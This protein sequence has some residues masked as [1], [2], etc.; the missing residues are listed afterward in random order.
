MI[1]TSNQIPA[2]YPNLVEKRGWLVQN[3]GYSAV[4]FELKKWGLFVPFI[5]Y[6]TSK[7][8]LFQWQIESTISTTQHLILTG[9][10]F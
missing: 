1:I 8:L 3:M 4:G 5:E 9:L 6:R 10:K 2:P 7:N